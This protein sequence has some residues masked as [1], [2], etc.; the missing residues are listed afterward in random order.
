MS[1]IIINRRIR[2]I[3]VF[4]NNYG[5][6]NCMVVFRLIRKMFQARFVV[7]GRTIFRVIMRRIFKI[8]SIIF[9]SF[10]PLQTR[11]FINIIFIF[12]VITLRTI[13]S[14]SIAIKIRKVVIVI[15]KIKFII[16]RWIIDIIIFI[17]LKN[18]FINKIYVIFWKNFLLI[19]ILNI[20]NI[21]N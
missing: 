19:I 20:L 4:I 7:R 13:S 15:K 5:I 3:R 18:F 6:N 10:N 2:H 9:N 14:G 1:S 17:I 21:L 12:I 8:F 16:F 11:T